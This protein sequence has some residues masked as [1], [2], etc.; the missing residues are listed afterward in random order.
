MQRR[1]K[2]R[3]VLFDAG[4]TLI[5]PRVDRIARTLTSLGYRA[6][7]EDFYRAERAGKRK[8]DEWLWPQLNE[9]RAPRRADYYYWAEYLRA[10][11]EIV[12]VPEKKRAEVATEI[13]EGFK[14]IK[15]WSRMFDGTSDYLRALRGRGYFLA[16]ISNSLGLIEA[17]LE[18]VSLAQ[19]FRFILDSYWVGI[20]KPH[21]DIFKQA[22]GRCGMEP[23]QAVYVG[24]LYST[25]VGGAHGAGLHGVLMDWVGA[26]PRAASPRITSL[27]ELDGV[28]TRIEN[29]D[30]KIKPR[31]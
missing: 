23:A 25:D 14:D 9:G 30:Y 11:V 26:Y 17:Q 7:V 3:A 4:N 6:S 22:L 5:F 8:L 19:H 21:P 24:D 1:K 13:G 15:A 2:I 10:L 31:L 27:P 16:V 18:R 20:E 29:G 12:G 28:L